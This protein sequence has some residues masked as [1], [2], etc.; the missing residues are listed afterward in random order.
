MSASPIES[1]S[2]ST[3]KVSDVTAAMTAA[4]VQRV[5]IG[6]RNGGTRL[7]FIHSYSTVP[8]THQHVHSRSEL[9]SADTCRRRAEKQP[10]E[11]NAARPIYELGIHNAPTRRQSHQAEDIHTSHT[12]HSLHSHARDVRRIPRSQTRFRVAIPRVNPGSE[13]RCNHLAWQVAIAGRRVDRGG[14]RDTTHTCSHVAC[15]NMRGSG[16]L[17]IREQLVVPDRRVV[18]ILEGRS[19]AERTRSSSV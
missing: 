15:G 16:F 5:S 7:S 8:V 11:E 13:P 4:M 3:G 19:V 1:T 12:S 14:H 18:G 2:M 9:H 6:G 10:T 17:G